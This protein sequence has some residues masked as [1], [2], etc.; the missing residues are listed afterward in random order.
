[1]FLKV[2]FLVNTQWRGWFFLPVEFPF[3]A[4]FIDSVHLKITEFE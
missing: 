1:M 3:N 4:I 2:E